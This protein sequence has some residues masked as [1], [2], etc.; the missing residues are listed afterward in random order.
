MTHRIV[1]F[2]EL[3]KIPCDQWIAMRVPYH[4]AKLP[5]ADI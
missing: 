2:L 1:T 5:S 3:R 4:A